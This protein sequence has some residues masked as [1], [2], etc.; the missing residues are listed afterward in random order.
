MAR[1]A[2]FEKS[3]SLFKKNFTEAVNKK[4]MEFGE[5]KSLELAQ[6][7]VELTKRNLDNAQPA[8]ESQH[9]IQ[10]IKDS[11]KIKK[12]KQYS[13]DKKK[14]GYTINIPVDSDGLVMFLEYGTGLEGLRNPHPETSKSLA[15]EFK[16]GWDYAVN[17]NNTKT[18]YMR[19]SKNQQV[20][21][22]QPCYI[23]RNGKRGF[24]FRKTAK[25][26]IDMADVQFKNTYET[27]YSWV[28]GYDRVVKK[29]N[30]EVKT[31][32]IKPYTRYH[33]N[34]ITYTSRTTYVLSSGIKP[35]RFIYNAKLE[36]RGMINNKR[37]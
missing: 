11:I 5:E 28:S 25:S 27:K 18:V 4:I 26:Y 15:Q 16:I 8:P 34:P 29:K 32:H 9:F 10:K 23:T 2:D 7:F 19:N 3:L 22:Q 35:V 36:L 1:N 31:I 17:R 20:A 37:I 33:K 24:V 13:E 14:V 6:T 30:G 21:I 12:T